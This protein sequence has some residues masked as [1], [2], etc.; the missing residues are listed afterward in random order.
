MLKKVTLSIFSLI[1]LIFLIPALCLIPSRGTL[2][3]SSSKA[4]KIQGEPVSKA[5]TASTTASSDADVLDTIT[6][7]NKADQS[8]QSYPFSEFLT[9]VVASE[10]PA[11]FEE[12]ALKAQ[13]VAARTYLLQRVLYYQKNGTPKEH[14]GALTCTDSTHCQ[15]YI[16]KEERLKSW[17]QNADLY[18]KKVSGAVSGTANIIMTYDGKPINAV[19]HSMSSGATESAQSVW[20]SDVPYLKS[21][22]SS[23]DK[24]AP[25]YQTEVTLTKEQLKKVLS[26]HVKDVNFEHGIFGNIERS[27]TG[28]IRSIVVGNV[29]ITGAQFRKILNLRSTNIQFS[30]EGNS[31]HMMVRGYGHGVGMSQYG[32]NFLAKEG[33]KYP[34]ILTSYYTG[35]RVEAYRK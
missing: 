14:H 1:L 23:L 8:V 31:V 27:N 16:A 10:M 9:C 29:K 33:K 18:W 28:S 3:S 35:I 11:T 34:E 17:G 19:F 13:A 21:V 26:D 7:Y 12:E 15:A 5:Q 4:D 2:S 25:Q 32:A 6:V 30:V 24:N 20:G 22:N